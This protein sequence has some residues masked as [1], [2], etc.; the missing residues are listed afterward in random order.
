MSAVIA[1][2]ST[3]HQNKSP[4]LPLLLAWTNGGRNP[5]RDDAHARPFLNSTGISKSAHA[6]GAPRRPSETFTDPAEPRASFGPAASLRRPGIRS[7]VCPFA[8]RAQR[9]TVCRG[10]PSGLICALQVS[11]ARADRARPGLHRLPRQ[12]ES[13]SDPAR[14]APAGLHSRPTSRRQ[15]RWPLPRDP[16]RRCR[17]RRP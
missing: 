5:P 7:R 6:R 8:P 14:L 17:G 11:S 12:P 15:L 10:G 9:P 13:E 3:F 16:C 1:S 2:G 4:V